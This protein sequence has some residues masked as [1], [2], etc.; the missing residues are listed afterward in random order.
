[1]ERLK[2]RK[3][4]NRYDKFSK[5]FY[6]KVQKAFIKIAKTNTK[7]YIILDNSKDSPEV[8]KIIFKKIMNLLCK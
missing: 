5:N 4:K 1:M 3:N 2:K 6:D 7:R 8:E